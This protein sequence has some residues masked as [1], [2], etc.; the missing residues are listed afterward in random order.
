M[1]SIVTKLCIGLVAFCSIITVN[2]QI[3]LHTSGDSTMAIYNV[4]TSDIKGVATPAAA[5][6][7][8]ESSKNELKWAVQDDSIQVTYLPINSKSGKQ[9]FI[10]S[11]S[12]DA[13]VIM[14]TPKTKGIYID[15]AASLEGTRTIKF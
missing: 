12:T 11:N 3:T 8:D 2:A 4:S 1:K 15:K 5:L 9:V 13:S 7:L 10:S 6:S 14:A